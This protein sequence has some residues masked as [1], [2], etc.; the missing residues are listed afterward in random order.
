MDPLALLLLLASCLNKVKQQ[1]PT[2]FTKPVSLL[3]TRY[4]ILDTIPIRRGAATYAFSV[5]GRESQLI[6]ARYRNT[7]YLNSHVHEINISFAVFTSG[8]RQELFMDNNDMDT[9]T[10]NYK[11]NKKRGTKIFAI[12]LPVYLLYYSCLL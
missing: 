7:R 2:Q 5:F 6:L 12:C 4:S 10:L 8:S 11:A 9:I 3:A 1:P